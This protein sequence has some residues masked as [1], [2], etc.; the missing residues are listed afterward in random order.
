MLRSLTTGALSVALALASF[1]APADAQS[2]LPA[3]LSLPSH[4]H[5][6][7][8]CGLAD[9]SQHE[10][11]ETSAVLAQ[12]R[13]AHGSTQQRFGG[14][15]TITIPIAYH[16]VLGTGVE[17]PSYDVIVEQNDRMNVAF[18]G[19]GFRFVIAY[20]GTVVNDDWYRV[21][22]PGETS[23]N[24]PA[25]LEMKTELSIDPASTLNVFFTEF[26]PSFLGGG[27]LGYGAFPDRWAE[28]QVEWSI[29]NRIGTLPGG[30]ANGYNG[31][32][33]MVHEVGHN[34]NLYHTFQNNGAGT[35][36][37]HAD[38][39][40]ES[41]GDRVCDTPA[42]A[43]S[44]SVGC[45]GP[46]VD[47]CP[48][49]AGN[50]PNE[51][52][53][54]Y[55]IDQCATEFSTG[56][57]ERAHASMA[58]FRPTIYNASLAVGTVFQNVD[59]DETYIGFPETQTVTLFN[60]TD[61]ASSVSA[62]A[63]PDGYALSVAAPFSLP[64]GGSLQ[65]EVTFDPT[66]ETTYGGELVFTTE[67]GTPN[68]SID[69]D[70]FGR[71][72]PDVDATPRPVVFQL[73]AGASASAQF[74]LL[75]TGPGTL[76]WT[77]DG[78]AGR[79][80]AGTA[81]ARGM[82]G[83]DAFGYTWSDSRSDYGPAYAFEDIVGAPGTFEI[84]LGDDDASQIFLPFAF[85]FYGDDYSLA[86]IVS[87]GRVEFGEEAA[88]NT[89]NTPIPRTSTP[90]GMLAP[91]WE[92]LNPE[93]SGSVHYSGTPERAIVQWTDVARNRDE[94]A[95]LTFQAILYPDGRVLYQ[96]ETLTGADQR[97]VVG[98]ENLDGTDGLQMSARAE[99]LE[100]GL[101]VLIAPP[102]AFVAAVSPM[103]GTVAPTSSVSVSV[104]VSVPATQLAGTYVE[105]V[106]VRSND[107]DRR[108][109]DVPVVV[110][111]NPVGAP[112]IPTPLAPDY[113]AVNVASPAV[114]TWS[115]VGA[116]GYDVQVATDEDFQNMV[117]EA[118]DIATTTTSA[119]LERGVYY[120]RVRAD[121]GSLVSTWSAPY[122]FG[123][124]TA[125]ANE[126]APS[127]RTAATR[128]VGA[129]PNPF[130]ST[131]TVRFALEEPSAVSVVVYDVLGQ[132][133]ARLADG[134]FGA[135]THEAELQ[136]EGL[137]PGVYL[138]RLVAGSV[139]DTQQILLAR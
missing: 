99:F 84:A 102:T 3:S 41:R 96:Y 85:P 44:P 67:D 132:Q 23:S 28:G 29:I 116:A 24:N 83:P 115:D 82:G 39:L 80:A 110:Q 54:N 35:T 117:F 109:L 119:P 61:E 94:A 133:V 46:N 81:T 131:A 52:F 127:E 87:N 107:P 57:M 138:V 27:L 128:L 79:L 88:T 2:R 56:Q 32:D 68:V 43:A 91:F 13:A 95:R 33:T 49:S 78:V 125:V 18:E 124:N 64:A 20:A 77:A 55:L 17:G 86:W 122:V 48:T 73:E 123:V 114:F 60:A 59:F 10:M 45:P 62:I 4:D 75:N 51:N 11:D 97:E 1:A 6:L 105:R 40:C 38:D 104:N 120:W 21:V 113:A 76:D 63:V 26:D 90:N 36:G 112:A 98:V 111:V 66:A 139:V 126:D 108:V 137:A 89:N 37:C 134:S 100:E 12:Y 47:T 72:A 25:A 42:Q 31:G 58:A 101:A 93:A 70:G 130:G 14:F 106:F 15:P 74:D 5:T 16:I 53:M 71:L 9:L 34:I 135:G 129:F 22:A 118:E 103:G 121:A 65:I 50:D 136:G 7:Q 19:T 92:D 8:R 69:L 30:N